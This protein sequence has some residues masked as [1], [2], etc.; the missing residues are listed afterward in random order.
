MGAAERPTAKTTANFGCTVAYHYNPHLAVA[1]LP[2]LRHT[3][4]LAAD[5][6]L[7]HLHLARQ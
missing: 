6:S 5:R 1:L 4:D 7:P 3:S 2:A